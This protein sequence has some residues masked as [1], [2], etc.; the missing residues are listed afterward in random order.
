MDPL[1][2]AAEAALGMRVRRLQPV[3][4]GD[5]NE[6]YRISA[7]DGQDYFLKTHQNPPEDLYTRE[8]EGLNWLR[9][10]DA[11]RIPQCFHHSSRR[12]AEPALLIL[13]WIDSAPPCPNHDELLGRG[14][15][16]I[17]LKTEAEFGLPETNY[18]GSLHQ[19]NRKHKTWHD[20]YTQERLLP[21]FELAARA[22]LVPSNLGKNFDTL[23]GRIGDILGPEEPPSRLHG[24]LWGGNTIRDEKGEPCLIDPAIYAGHREVDLAMMQLFGGFNPRVFAAYEE[25]YPT[26]EGSAGR[27]PLYQLYYLL[28]HLNLFGSSYLSAVHRAVDCY[29]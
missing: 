7:A 25:S 17:H 16:K 10:A 1:K 2:A 12:G 4:G 21:Q 18:I 23:L 20:F 24:D 3:L 19:R 14:L 28:V 5:I 26:T 15:A 11:I 29:S 27:I 6:A 22:G 8:A 13:E 9:E